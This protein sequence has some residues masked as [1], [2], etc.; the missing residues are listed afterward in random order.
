[1]SKYRDEL[2]KGNEIT[3]SQVIFRG[4]DILTKRPPE[5]AFEDYRQLRGVQG[6]V[7]Q[8]LHPFA[9]NPKIAS[10]MGEKVKLIR[11]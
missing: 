7:L 8:K 1:M 9:P 5:M 4:K 2:N 10:Q 11:R 3:P 6:K